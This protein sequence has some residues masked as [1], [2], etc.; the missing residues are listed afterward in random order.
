V[1]PLEKMTVARFVQLDFF[2]ARLQRYAP[3]PPTGS[4]Q[5]MQKAARVFSPQAR[6]SPRVPRANT[7]SH[8]NL[9]LTFARNAF[10]VTDGFDFTTAGYRKPGFASDTV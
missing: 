2:S 4:S 3:A 10:E 6:I 5:A 8:G 7:S 1:L 9:Q